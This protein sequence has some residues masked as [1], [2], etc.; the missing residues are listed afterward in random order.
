[1]YIP[2]SINQLSFLKRFENSSP[3][4]VKVS[5]P[6]TAALQGV[7]AK[8]RPYTASTVVIFGVDLSGPQIPYGIPSSFFCVYLFRL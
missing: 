8:M 7:T 3:Q 2:H 5:M 6:A 1:M 4:M